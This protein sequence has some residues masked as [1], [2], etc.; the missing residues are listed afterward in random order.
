MNRG[1]V[2]RKLKRKMKILCKDCNKSI[3]YCF[4]RGK[5]KIRD[6]EIEKL[7]ICWVKWSFDLMVK[8]LNGN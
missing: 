4:C 2:I 5:G 8:E 7:P 1:E 6:P 3:D